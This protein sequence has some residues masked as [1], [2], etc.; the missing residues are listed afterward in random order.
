MILFWKILIVGIMILFFPVALIVTLKG[1]RDIV[2]MLADLGEDNACEDEA[3][4]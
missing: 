1:F 4:E 3:D 2:L